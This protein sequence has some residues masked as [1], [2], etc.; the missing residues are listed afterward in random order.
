MMFNL[1]EIYRR[2]TTSFSCCWC[3]WWCWF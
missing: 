3:F 2:L 1:I